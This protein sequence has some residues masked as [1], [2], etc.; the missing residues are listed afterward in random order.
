MTSANLLLVV[1]AGLAGLGLFALA[2]L[3]PAAA[4]AVLALAVPLVAGLD[5][6]AAVPLL[7]VNEALLLVVAAGFLVHRLPRWRAVHFTGLDVVVLGFCLVGVLV[8]WAVILLT[9]APAE[10]DDWLVVAAPVQYLV[11]YLLF[12]RVEVGDRD[13]RLFCNLAMAAS[14]PVAAVAVAE[15]VDLP[16]IRDLVASYYPAAPIPSWD[17]VY[18]PSSLLGHYSAVGAFGLLNFLLA[19]G[20]AATRHPG[21]RTRWLVLVMAV[22][23]LSLL[24]S[25]TYAPIA[26]LP[27]AAL[28]VLLFARRL[29]WRQ[30]AA[31]PAVVAAGA[32]LFW[33]E[34]SGRLLQ[35]F[36]PGVA[37]A[38]VA[39]PETLQTRVDYWQ[40]FFVPALLA[41]GPWLGTGTLIP[42]EVPRRLVDFVDNGYLW[43]AFR[44]GVPGLA[45]LLALLASVAATAWASRAAAEPGRRVLGAVCLGAVVSVALLDTTSEY[46]T[47]TAVSQEFWMLVGLLS[48]SVVAGRLRVAAPALVLR[49]PAVPRPRLGPALRRL[50]PERVLVRASIG[51]L[52]GF[53][54]ARA[55]GFGFQVVAGRALSP[56]GYGRLT[57]ALAVA[58]VATVLLTTAPLGLSRFLSRSEGD[59]AEQRSYAVNWLAVVGLL[60][61]VSAV[62]TGAVATPLGLGGW[63]LAGLLANLLGV[64]ALE[65]YR[66][67][68]RG[69]GRYALTSVF[70]VI[71][72][73]LQLAAVLT[74][75]ARGWA[76]APLFLLVYGLSSVVAL[77]LLA[78]L[79][80]G[81]GLDLR[82]LRP[83]VML[84]IG[85]FMRPVLLQ[86]V[87]WNV[88]FNADLILLA[89][90]R[91]AAETGAYGAAKAIA[92]GFAL[93]PTAI[94]F[95]F[96]PRVARMSEREVR[97]H[98]ARA[99]GLTAAVSVPAAAVVAVAAGPLTAGLFG[100]RYAAAA[101]PLAV[102]MSGMVPYALRTVLNSLWLGLGHPVVETASSAAGM[103]VTLA[104]AAWLVPG[105]GALGAAAAFS[106]GAAAMLL[107]DAA[108]SAWAFGAASPRVRH[109]AALAPAPA[110]AAPAASAGPAPPGGLAVL[111]ARLRRAAVDRRG[112][113]RRRLWPDNLG[114]QPRRPATAAI[115]PAGDPA[116]PPPPARPASDVLGVVAGSGADAD[117]GLAR[118]AA[119][120]L[121]LPVRVGAGAE[122]S[123]LLDRALLEHWPMVTGGAEA[124]AALPAAGTA[125]L[126]ALLHV[127]GTLFLPGLTE[128]SRPALEALGTR[129]GFAPPAVRPAPAAR[130]LRLAAEHAAFARE[131]AGTRLAS[132][133]AGRALAGAREDETLAWSETG[134]ERLPAVVR[135]R[136][137]RG[138]VV[139]SVLEA[140]PRPLREAFAADDPGAA[141]VA[142]LL[143]RERYGQA[144][145][146]APTPLANVSVDD[147]ALREGALG[148]RYGALAAR[149]RE[150]RFHV[151]VATVPR[152][153]PLAE[154][155]VV[156]RLRED[157]DHLSAC[158]HGCDHDGYEFYR[159]AGRRTRYAPRPLAE[160]RLALRRA[161]A[162]ARDFEA[163]LG[164]RLDPVMV[165]P[166]GVGPAALLPE[167]RRLGFLASC[168]Y[169]DKYPL[170]AP[171]PSDPDLGLRPA[172]LA[173][174]G[175]PL[176]WR[177]DLDD[178]GCLLDLVLGRPV[179]LFG[180]RGDLGRDF[181]RLA[182]RA[183]L[184]SRAT[185][186]AV[187][188]RSLGE[189]ARHAH[190]QRRAAG[191]RWSVLMTA[192][193]ACLHN[194]D[195]VPRDCAVLR[196]HQPPATVLQVD[197]VTRR[198]RRP[199]VT[200]PAGGRAVVRLVPRARPPV[201]TE[202]EVPR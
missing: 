180:H 6:G 1:P 150:D 177:R 55:L 49:A 5:R 121:G 44:A 101:L 175:F 18:R 34:I 172:D 109:R 45:A 193:E 116:P 184:V 115:L 167:L 170:E 19:L 102:L 37:G 192:D 125:S 189:I 132:A 10:R 91:G 137:G 56:A 113:P 65:T 181:D 57:Y 63:M 2:A 106:A 51:V 114:Y 152:E 58:N 146:H 99:L 128:A 134:G 64:T 67:H 123:R 154:A 185:H 80:R 158:F 59:R 198:E 178:E 69:L 76:S 74:A 124:L 194:P 68:Q 72:N 196:P 27:V 61:G 199:V 87:F 52:L 104:A 54:L 187:R 182:E 71:A 155:A 139:L 138:A 179:L 88:W 191:G 31:A 14:I 79:T 96:A 28:V 201:P 129:I 130:W 62:V 26:A 66:E 160:Q 200:I 94:A 60:L 42:A 174:E 46:L 73:A 21:F 9:H 108:V 11:V 120:L 48:G 43:Q 163:R 188:W 25:Q 148:L 156:R 78:P 84:G 112:W 93:V 122:A 15:A 50:A 17:P 36:G 136:V 30:L 186:G 141:V 145:W 29:P 24:T 39:L 82:S 22:N 8:P 83:G 166:Y 7:R 165:F 171:V 86:A 126:S 89:H 105:R 98:L 23:L 133:C 40:A 33:P 202:T 111:A 12:S 176:L 142:L 169:G 143:L 135:R 13:L 81:P 95:V 153:L 183:R 85:A 47:F 195:P 140:G 4:C 70:Y 20:L 35:Q 3:R 90:L 147:P 118:A 162:H 149:A 38:G 197:G 41:H 127:G 144:A 119:A 53:G 117:V 100:G 161:V 151:T 157:R 97:G 16:G 77:A 92:N 173:W 190:L 75:A 131:L 110:A 159:T 164:H 103:A 107:V 168:N 32:A